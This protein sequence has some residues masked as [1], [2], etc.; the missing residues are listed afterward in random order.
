M[1]YVIIFF[2]FI[3]I[4]QELKNGIEHY[5]IALRLRNDFGLVLQ[6]KGFLP[7]VDMRSAESTYLSSLGDNPYTYFALGDLYRYKKYKERE[8]RYFEMG[9]EKSTSYGELFI[10]DRLFCKNR[11]W[12]FSELTRKKI[13]QGLDAPFYTLSLLYQYEGA[14]NI[15]NGFKKE[16]IRDLRFSGKIDPG[17]RFIPLML[18]RVNFPKIKSA[19]KYFF[20][21]LLTFKFFRNQVFLIHALYRYFI[22]FIFLLSLYYII[23]LFFKKFPIITRFISSRFPI[24]HWWLV[25]ILILIILW[26]YPLY[27]IIFSLLIISPIISKKEFIAISVILLLFSSIPLFSLVDTKILNGV[28]SD[29]PMRNLIYLQE[30]IPESQMVQNARMENLEYYCTMGNLY[31]PIDSKIAFSFYFRGLKKLGNNPTLL[32][33]IGCVYARIGKEDSAFYWFKRAEKF[34]PTSAVPHLN[35]SNLYI[36]NLKFREAEEERNIAQKYNSEI[37]ANINPDTL[38]LMKVPRPGMLKTLLHSSEMPERI[39]TFSP[40][41]LLIMGIICILVIALL[42][43][44]LEFTNFESCSVCGGFVEGAK[45]IEDDKVCNYCYHR[46]TQTKS[47]GIR[48]R[49]KRLIKRNIQIRMRLKAHILNIFLPGSGFMLIGD[50]KRSIFITLITSYLIIAFFYP[51]TLYGNPVFSIIPSIGKIILEF[52]IFILYLYEFL[53][54]ERE[55]RKW[56]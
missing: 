12:E 2:G 11:L 9:I 30:I 43:K 1:I 46:L 24:H 8:K 23:A 18:I 36:K 51:Y 53:I 40:F 50:G 52:I 47:K 49:F 10:L 56:H 22:L 27:G 28:K 7:N 35:L 32:N 25:G 45:T 31:Y 42:K 26:L 17:N 55:V 5:H 3:D 34:N 4:H 16:G 44:F 38:F 29:A 41:L 6:G 14:K 15:N 19:I 21:Y 48:E 54:L 37:T 33:N 20:A 13:I 39:F